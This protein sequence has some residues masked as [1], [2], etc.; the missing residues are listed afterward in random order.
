MMWQILH[1]SLSPQKP[2]FPFLWK[3]KTLFLCPINWTVA[4]N[5]SVSPGNFKDSLAWCN[6]G[7][8]GCT[9]AAVLS[10]GGSSYLH[11]F[12]LAANFMCR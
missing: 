9:L 3:T 5:Y 11:P 1:P 6:K 10:G 4:L 2:Q 12:D 8:G 7:V